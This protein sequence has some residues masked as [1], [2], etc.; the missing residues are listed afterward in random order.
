MLEVEVRYRVEDFEAVRLRLEQ[1]GGYL[2]QERTEVDRYFNAPHRDFRATDEALRLRRVGE[3]NR[4]TYKGPRRDTQTKTRPEIEVPLADGETAARLT[5]ELLLALGFRFVAVVRKQRQIYR[6][7]RYGFTLELCRDEVEKAGVF[8]ELEILTEEQRYEEA[9]AVLL[10]TAVEL[11]LH[12]R[13]LRS[14]LQ[15]VLEAAET[16]KQPA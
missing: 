4:L 10:R 5:E 7:Q 9:Q 13:E 11:G 15:M 2:H 12:E 3:S 1:W 6:F 14:Y 16:E 8:V